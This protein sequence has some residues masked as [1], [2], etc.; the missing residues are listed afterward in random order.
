MAQIEAKQ[1]Q[2]RKQVRKEEKRINK[3]MNKA[4]QDDSDE[5]DFDP[6]DMLAKRQD[7]WPTT[8]SHQGNHAKFLSN[9]GTASPFFCG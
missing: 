2:M 8:K 4:A 3:L 7:H 9:R 6:H 5:D 1:K